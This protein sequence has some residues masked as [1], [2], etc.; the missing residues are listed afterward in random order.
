MNIRHRK[1]LVPALLL[2]LVIV[3]ISTGAWLWLTRKQPSPQPAQNTTT[4]PKVADQ[5]QSLRFAAMGDM[6]AHDSV[7]SNAKTANGYDFTQ[8]FTRIR[9]LYSGADAVFCNSETPVAGAT[10]GISGYPTFNGPTEFARD[11]SAVGCNVINL[12]TNHVDDKGQAG[13]NA[14]IDTWAALKPL[15]YA[16]AN[17]DQASQNTVSY[18]T[19]NGIKVAFVAFADFSNDKSVSSYG[20]NIYHNTALVTTL[21]QQARANADLVIVSAHWGTEDSGVVNADQQTTA[22]LF[23]QLGADVVI[24]TGPHVLQKVSS[25]PKNGGGTTLVWYSIGNMLTSQLQ[26]NELTSGVAGFTAQKTNGKIEIKDIT[27][28]GT[29]M[30]YDWPA[31]DRAT[32]K[33]E[34]RANLALYPLADASDQVAKFGATLGER[35]AYLHTILG[36]DVSVQVTP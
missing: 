16:G 33:L 2:A 34:T 6:I 1:H 21:L 15:A 7:V 14:T 19:K 10:F 22:Q 26:T 27:F 12:A 11:L 32:S 5:P 23:A 35:T 36:T 25:L 28:K 13:I 29:F 9:R 18:F 30:S 24:G 17:K 20:L 4:T 31:A 8:Y 3:C